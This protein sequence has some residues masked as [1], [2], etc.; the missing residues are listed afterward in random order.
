[1]QQ[2][3]LSL[4]RQVTANCLGNKS[5]HRASVVAP[6]RFALTERHKIEARAGAFNILNH[7]VFGGPRSSLTG[8]NVG[9]ILGANDPRILQFALKYIF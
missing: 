8:A 2:W 3:N 4:Q 1:M 5:S 9:R 7:P 6:R